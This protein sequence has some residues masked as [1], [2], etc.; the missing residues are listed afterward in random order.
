MIVIIGLV[1]LVAAVLVGVA[2]V[3]A[4]SGSAHTLT[5]DFAVFGYH[6]T[7]S[8]GVLFLYGIVVGGIGI[9]G[10]ALLL[11][12]A[13]RSARRGSAAR[14]ELKAA[15]RD[16]S[17]AEARPSQPIGAEREAPTYYT[18]TGTTDIADQGPGNTAAPYP[19]DRPA[20]RRRGVSRIFGGAGAR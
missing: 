12:G 20:P 9:A 17:A 6:V 19:G 8:T 5:D 4:N 16:Y 13:R 11:A 1:I 7:G 3:F 18:H 14:R 2:G 15:R 10:L